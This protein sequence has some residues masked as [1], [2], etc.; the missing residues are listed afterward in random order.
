[1]DESDGFE[2]GDEIPYVVWD[3][4]DFS[5]ITKTIGDRPGFQ[6]VLSAD[7]TWE[8]SAATQTCG[9]TIQ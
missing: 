5:I 4:L 6:L 3:D 7:G 8:V 1:M 2:P 9:A